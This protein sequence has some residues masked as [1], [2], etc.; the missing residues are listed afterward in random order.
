MISGEGIVTRVGEGVT[1]VGEAQE[2]N[3]SIQMKIE[4]NTRLNKGVRDRF[5]G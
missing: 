2:V 3:R 5:M 4:D 1:W